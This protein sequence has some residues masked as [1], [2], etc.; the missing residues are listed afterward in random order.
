[1]SV[2]GG[3]PRQTWISPRNIRFTQT[4]GVEGGTASE[5]IKS[6]FFLTQP[7]YLIAVLKGQS[8]TPSGSFGKPRDLALA[9]VLTS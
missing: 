2:W 6:H 9:A 3:A 8:T 7:H 1:M 5:W 4:L